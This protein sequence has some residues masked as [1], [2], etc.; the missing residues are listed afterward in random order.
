MISSIVPDSLAPIIG[1][2]CKII[3][4][5]PIPLIKPDITGYGIKCI[6]FPTFMNPS[7]I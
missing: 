4:I 2:I 1:F 7:A 6:N 5:I 3:I